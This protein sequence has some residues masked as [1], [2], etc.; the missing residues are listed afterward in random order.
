V[1]S[2]FEWGIANHDSGAADLS[3]CPRDAYN[4]F[5]NAKDEDVELEGSKVGADG[6]GQRWAP[7]WAGLIAMAPFIGVLLGRA[8]FYFDDHFR[9]STPLAG[10][11]AEAA[12]GHY[13][14][15]WNPWVLT[16]TPLVA[17]RGSLVAHPGM[18]L[19]LVMEPSHAVGTLMVLL[20]GVLA[21]GSTA[22]LRALSVRTVLAVGVGAAI[23]LSGPALS[24]TSNAPYLASLAFLPLVLLSALR[25]A[26][27]KR[28]SL[29]GGLALGMALLGGDLPGALLAAVVALVVFR[30]HGG[31]LRTEWPRLGAVAGIALLIG[32]G[33]WFP[34]VWALPLSERGAG[35][36]ASEAGRWSFHPAE[37]LGFIWP[38]PLGLP[39]PSF[40]F[41]PF[42]WLE[43]QRLFLHSIWVGSLV[44]VAALLALRKGGERVAR[45]FTIVALVLLVAAT[46]RWTPLWPLLRPLFTFIRYPSKLAAPAALLL[47][48]AGAVVIERLLATPSKLRNLCLIVMGLG[49]LGATGGVMVQAMLARKAGAPVEIVL[50][51][52]SALRADT[53]RIAILAA[54]GAALFTFVER[55]R[56]ALSRAVPLLAILIFLDVFATTADLAWTRV[57]VTPSRAAFLPDVGPRGPRVMRLEEVSVAR[58]SLNEKAFSEEQLRHAALQSPLTNLVYHTGVLEPYGLYLS[59]VARAMADMAS[60]NPVALAEVTASDVVLAAPSSRATWLAN[61]VDTRRLIPMAS[62][63]AGALVLRVPHAIPRSF[64]VSAVTLAPHEEIPL[65]LA[66]NPDRV[67]ISAEKELLEGGVVPA[68]ASAIPPSLLDQATS[69]PVAVFP[70][71]WR[72]GAAS[73][74]VSTASPALLVEVDTF[75]PGWHVFVDGQEQPILQANVF[76]RAVVIPPGAHTVF[77]TFRPR[78]VIASLLTSWLALVI[79]MLSLRL[80]KRSQ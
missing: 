18:L 28:A 27:G 37:I 34:V 21:A 25:L 44:F 24:Y 46:G 31:R 4:A 38:H 72:P 53:L 1:H 9:F 7:L 35:I 15:L 30:A 54:V 40:S 55:G 60:A 11:V 74:Q 49:V 78:L 17:E 65:R 41:W 75:M 50:L 61:A 23:G 6:I 22:L 45:T 39:L 73:Y 8:E 12:R 42:R 52:A 77:W 10:L 57:P 43:Q 5:R 67:L 48:F 71:A 13:L 64:L 79:G 66:Q 56:F 58:L 33:S 51:A 69:A 26:E 29:S 14:P 70:T 68:S 62:V 20:L 2:P 19:A 76:G 3:I 16:G 36:A 59:D 47:A 80:P 63:A 32:A